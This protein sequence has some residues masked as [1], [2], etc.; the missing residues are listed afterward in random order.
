M[1]DGKVTSPL[2]VPC[3]P[4]PRSPQRCRTQMP[5]DRTWWLQQAK[6][7]SVSKIMTSPRPHKTI[8]TPRANLE[9]LHFKTP[10][11]SVS[12]CD[13][14]LKMATTDRER[15]VEK[16]LRRL[17]PQFMKLMDPELVR[18]TLYGRELLTWVEYQSIG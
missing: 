9:S 2:P 15:A 17:T 18:H 11:P 1:R 10:K 16:A 5:Q 6:N 4:W 12:L 8:F 13:Q 3:V 14:T 7:A